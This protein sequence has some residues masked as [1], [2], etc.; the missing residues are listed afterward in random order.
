ME[1][2]REKLDAV[3]QARARSRERRGGVDRPD[4]SVAPRSPAPRVVERLLGRLV[5]VEA[6]GHHDRDVRARRA[7]SSSHVA[8][9]DFDA[10]LAEGVRATGACDHLRHP[11]AADE[12]RVEPLERD[13]AWLRRAVDRALAPL[14]GARR[15]S[16]S[17]ALAALGTPQASPSRTRSRKHLV[18]GL[19][20]E[21]EH[22]GLARQG[23]GD[24]SRRRRMR[25][26]RRRTG[27][28]S[29]SGR[30]RD[31]RARLESRP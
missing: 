7:R 29:R 22:A 30:A 10:R 21:R 27:P 25:R 2:V 4:A 28:G 24:R 8:V 9:R 14:P 18:E 19:G 16:R 5:G 13:D 20:V 31:A 15:S 17:E 26:R 12:R 3:D 6:A 23:A 1:E 11:M